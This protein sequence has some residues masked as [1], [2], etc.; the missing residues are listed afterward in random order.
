MSRAAKPGPT[1]E[2][3]G[4]TTLDKL[5]KADGPHQ[6]FFALN[7]GG[8]PVSPQIQ[9]ASVQ[10]PAPAPADQPPTP[11]TASPSAADTNTGIGQSRSTAPA[12]LNPANLPS[13]N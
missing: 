5:P 9:Q 10:A 3:Q 1:R 13:G 7:D 11:P 2:T 6:G 12:G 4:L 8:T